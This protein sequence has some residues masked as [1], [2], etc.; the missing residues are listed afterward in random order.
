[1]Q[2]IVI[3][4]LLLGLCAGLLLESASAQIIRRQLQR[5]PGFPT[6]PAY[7][8]GSVLRQ[9]GPIIQR[10]GQAA[11]RVLNIVR[12][13]TGSEAAADGGLKPVVIVSFASFDEFRRVIDI[14][15]QQIRLD[16][17]SI[18]EPVLLN[19]ALNLYERMVGQGFDTSQP[20]G[21]VLL[22]DGLLFYPIMFTPL[23]LDS[24][25]GQSLQN[26]YAERL[27]DGRTVIR[28]EIFRWPLGRLFVQEHN[29][30]AFIAPENLLNSLPD[31]PAALLQGLDREVLIAARFDLQNM[32]TLS[33]RAALSLSEM[34]AV[35]Q[36][37]TEI[38]K[39]VARLGI[40]YMRSLAEQADFLEYLFYYDEE[41]N[42]YVLAQTET[43]KPNTE[44]ARLMQERSHAESRL[45]GFYH[46]EGAVL[47]AHFVMTLTKVQRQQLEIILHEAIGKH[48]LSEKAKES[49]YRLED[50][51][52]AQKLELLFRRIGITYYTAL[53]GAVRSGT[54][55]GAS[56]W[57]QK[58]GILAAYNI[59]DGER[60]RQAFDAV[61][62]EM[63]TH[64]PDVYEK[65]VKKDYAEC[66]GFL[67]TSITFRLGDFIKNS[68][69]QG[70]TPPNLATR[71]TRIILGVRDDTVC[72]ALGQDSQPEKVLVEAIMGMRESKPVDDL[73]FIYSAY[74]LGRAFSLAG[75]PH[76]FTLLKL[77]ASGTNPQAW[78]YAYSHFTETTKTVTFRASG[79]LT[80]SLWRM[81][82][83][84]RP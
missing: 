71:E 84:M 77:A 58:H 34:K 62:E 12:Q 70:L 66:E 42:E 6:E 16:K 55:D 79:L 30:W 17:G 61:F 29:G 15:A 38:D 3:A 37:E 82:E 50:L 52:D 11:N 23:N 8:V 78:A 80:P 22:T 65:N 73:F 31:D 35:A 4:L 26:Q 21:I 28:Q 75:E 83:A 43:V 19:L 41:K 69:I 2:R 59:P 56:T 10:D 51:T 39:A 64:F 72:F 63:R 47:A 54:F 40:G 44:R 46:I 24:K 60:F 76:R 32:P 36:A 5:I 7:R 81:R 57:S 48:L 13:F 49:E 18:D 20:L 27:P 14:V 45:H 68:F 67:L 25:I 1:M 74:E 53:L 9:Q 33:T